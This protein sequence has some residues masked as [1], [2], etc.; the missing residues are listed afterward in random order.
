M[1]RGSALTFLSLPGSSE[2]RQHPFWVDDCQD[3]ANRNA[4]ISHDLLWYRT[5]R[6]SLQSGVRLVE[7]V[8]ERE[9]ECD[10]PIENR[11]VAISVGIL[12]HLLGASREESNGAMIHVLTTSHPAC[13]SGTSAH[14]PVVKLTY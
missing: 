2:D 14:W 12:E 10:W 9:G 5:K 3:S 7:W 1:L 6:L 4:G 13:C 8:R 11:G